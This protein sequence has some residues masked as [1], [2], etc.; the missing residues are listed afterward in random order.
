MNAK[1][2]PRIVVAHPGK[3]HSFRIAKALK[4]AGL[5]YKY[6]TTVYDK[7]DSF[8]MRL[9]KIFLRGDNLMRAGRRRCSNL[10]DSDIIQ[11]CELE[12]LFL[13][14]LIR[15]DKSKRVAKRYMRYISDKFQCRLARYLI[16]HD[17]DMIISYDTNSKILFD[18]LNRKAPDIIRV[19][20]NA[21]PNRNFLYHNY[22]EH[23]DCVGDFVKTLEACGYL[24][25]PNVAL[26]FGKESKMADYHIVASTYSERA[27]R[28]EGILPER[29]FR[30]PYGVDDNKFITPHREYSTK[31]LNVLFMGDVN[32]RKGIRQVLEAARIINSPKI[33][34]NIIGSGADHCSELFTPYRPYV[35]F[36]GYISFEE[37]LHQ[38]SC[39]H[40]FL[41]PT[42]GEGF[43]LVL[44]EAMAAGMP[45]ITTANCGGGDIVVDGEN[46]FLVEVGDVD[47]IVTR[48][49]WFLS[50]PDELAEM[51]L[52]AINAARNYT[53]LKYEEGIV[54][55]INQIIRQRGLI[56]H[57]I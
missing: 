6:A 21:H 49:R 57:Y 32:Q 54:D 40:V 15:I 42:M 28:F 17:V 35:N 24:T 16:R 10:E 14:L 11:F 56:S 44:L 37:L 53:W 1:K 4:D 26:Q 43:G 5:L 7:H 3:Q 55:S 9:A 30:V 27:L 51:G 50:H 12:S 31:L 23:W 22:H 29:I 41:F 19:M 18:I 38:L 25:D 20:D 48:L 45:V 2:V 13:L 47:A 33:V 46:G 52:N 39:N 34:F 8:W 36:L